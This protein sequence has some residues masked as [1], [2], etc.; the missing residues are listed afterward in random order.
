[1]PKHIL[2]A[3]QFDRNRL[4]NIF[5]QAQVI[6]KMYRNNPKDCLALLGSRE[7]WGDLNF[8]EPSTRTHRSFK[9]A[10]DR[11]GIRINFDT[12]SAAIS[13]SAAK[14]ESIENAF[15]NMYKINDPDTIDVVVL[16][17][18][19]DDAAERAAVIADTYNSSIINAG[20]G[21]KEHPTQMLLDLYTIFQKRQGQIDGTKIVIGGD[22]QASRTIHSLIIGLVKNYK[23][24][25][26]GVCGP[27]DYFLPT[28]VLAEINGRCQI[29]NF[30]TYAQALEWQPNFLYVTR[31]Q[32]ERYIPAGCSDSEKSK[33]I[34]ELVEKFSYLQI[35]DKLAQRMKEIG[36]Y[37]MHPQPVDSNNFNEI[38]SHLIDHENSLLL[39]Q[40]NNSVWVRMATILD[41][42][43]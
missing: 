10:F 1:M 21:K 26:I 5:Q 23:I 6:E 16:R 9:K 25:E 38:L 32:I 36:C 30:P 4:E 8:Y 13:S 11:L 12:T 43:T 35:N 39:T 42:L 37:Y 20:A 17:H 31:P 14:G 28:D 22:P 34:A 40:S 41:V 33:K 18:P 3:N 15:H 29:I 24:K 2:R 27:T 19:E 7:I